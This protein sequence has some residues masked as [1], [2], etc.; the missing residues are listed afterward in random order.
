MVEYGL[1]RRPDGSYAFALGVV[2]FDNDNVCVRYLDC[3]S[4]NGEKAEPLESFLA[5]YVKVRSMEVG[6]AGAFSTA[7]L[8]SELSRRTDNPYAGMDGAA[9]DWCI[10]ELH[11]SRVVM[12][13]EYPEQV[14]GK[15][16]F[17]SDREMRKYL[18]C[19]V[20]KDGHRQGL[21]P[22]FHCYRRVYAVADARFGF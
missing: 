14:E 18:E 22:G 4:P 7:E 21:P 3:P 16:T 19:R 17:D 15:I 2:M 5:G 10:G 9:E 6:S 13:K 12:G 11:P 8:L 1:Y 20:M